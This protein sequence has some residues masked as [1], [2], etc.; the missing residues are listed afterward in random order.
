MNPLVACALCSICGIMVLMAGSMSSFI[1]PWPGLILMGL[2]I[3]MQIEAIYL[4]IW[5]I[6]QRRARAAKESK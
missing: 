6:R 2:G 4:A 3:L 1:M 5:T